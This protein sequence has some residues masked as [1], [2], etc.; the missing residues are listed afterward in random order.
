MDNKASWPIGW[1]KSAAFP[2]QA[3]SCSCHVHSRLFPCARGNRRLVTEPGAES[4]FS[5]LGTSVCSKPRGMQTAQ[6]WT[7]APAAHSQKETLRATGQ[8][9]WRELSDCVIKGQS[10]IFRLGNWEMNVAALAGWLERGKAPLPSNYAL[11]RWRYL[12]IAHLQVLLLT[13]WLQGGRWSGVACLGDTQR[14]LHHC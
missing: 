6:R 3:Q 1:V 12:L 14:D 13:G 5:S 4:C 11:S 10:C 9:A 8:P 7:T 2:V